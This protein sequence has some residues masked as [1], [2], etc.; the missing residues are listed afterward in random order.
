METS[1][2]SKFRASS[3][4]SLSFSNTSKSELTNTINIIL[5]KIEAK[6]KANDHS[7]TISP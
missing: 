7:W 3:S 5:K 1:K 2:I 4:S 6:A